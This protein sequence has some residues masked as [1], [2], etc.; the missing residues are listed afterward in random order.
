MFSF[1]TAPILTVNYSAPG[2]QKWTVPLG[3]G[4]TYSFSLGDQLMQFSAFYYTNLVHP[5]SG[6]Q[7]SLQCSLD[8]LFP[9]TRGEDIA[10]VIEENTKP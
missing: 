7:T 2:D 6:P 3:A 1:S 9:V 5:M 10:Q 8:L 4:G